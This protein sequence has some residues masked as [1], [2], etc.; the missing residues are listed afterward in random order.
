MWVY[1]LNLQNKQ[2]AEKVITNERCPEF[3]M[4]ELN[5]R[6]IVLFSCITPR[7]LLFIGI[8]IEHEQQCG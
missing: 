5:Y 7:R 2:H 8:F 1:H 4:T 6:D 3:S